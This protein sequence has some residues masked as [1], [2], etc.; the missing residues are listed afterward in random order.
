MG[1]RQR[2]VH[3]LRD[4]EMTSKSE[5]R[6]YSFTNFENLRTYAAFVNCLWVSP[7][8]VQ[9]TCTPLLIPA[10]ENRDGGCSAGKQ[11][12]CYLHKRLAAQRL[13][14]HRLLLLYLWV[15]RLCNSGYPRIRHSS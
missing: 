9:F 15:G 1:E 11:E 3:L 13:T 12:I 7:N 5:G 4:G 2:S 8:F 6:T 10:T 14:T